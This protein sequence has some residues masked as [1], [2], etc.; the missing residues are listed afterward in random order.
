MFS[1][2]LKLLPLGIC[3]VAAVGLLTH[4]MGTSEIMLLLA[5]AGVIHPA[6]SAVNNVNPPK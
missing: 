5:A 1:D 2:P 3:V 6:I 4:T